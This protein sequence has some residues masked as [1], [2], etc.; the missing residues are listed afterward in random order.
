MDPR[1][2][3]R[4]VDPAWE[5]KLVELTPRSD[6]LSYLTIRWHPGSVRAGRQLHGVTKKRAAWVPVERFIIYNVLPD[7]KLYPPLLFAPFRLSELNSEG[8]CR[9]VLDLDRRAMD[10]NQWAIYRETGRYAQPFWVLQGNRGGHKRNYTQVESKVSVLNGGTGDPPALGDLPYAEPDRRTWEKLALL[11]VARFWTHSL[12]LYDRKPEM[13]D[14]LEEEAM[15]DYRRMLWD[16]MDE[17]AYEA[18][19]G[20]ADMN[21]WRGMI[22]QHAKPLAANAKD[23]TDYEA[24][25]REFIETPS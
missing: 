6:R 17:K 20:V 25:H 21:A 9:P 22:A 2:F 14:A 12:A 13:F 19:S 16:W 1:A 5:A 18:C 10:Q 24:E 15:K 23:T 7:P 8:F 11:D 4:E 3:Y